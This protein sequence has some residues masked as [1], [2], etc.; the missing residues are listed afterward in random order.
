ME[1]ALVGRDEHA[2]WPTKNL[3]RGPAPVNKNRTRKDAKI[4]T[5]SERRFG[6]AVLDRTLKNDVAEGPTAKNSSAIGE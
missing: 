5:R 1:S 2:V 4:K 3:A 6:D